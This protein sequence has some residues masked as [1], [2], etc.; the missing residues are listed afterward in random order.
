MRQPKVKV[1]LDLPTINK[2][3]AT[4]I[5]LGLTEAA[6]SLERNAT[7]AISKPYK[8]IQGYQTDLTKPINGYYTEVWLDKQLK[9]NDAGEPIKAIF[10][11]SGYQA[12]KRVWR[13]LYYNDGTDYLLIN[14]FHDNW[15]NPELKEI[16]EM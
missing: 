15:I 3:K 14:T 4:L 9:Y 1:E 12:Y 8:E 11:I 2:A 5:S 7:E 10:S 6:E 16:I 13:S